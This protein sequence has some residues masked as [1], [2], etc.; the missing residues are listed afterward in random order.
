MNQSCELKIIESDQYYY[1]GNIL[2]KEQLFHIND[3]KGYTYTVVGYDDK[4]YCAEID[5]RFDR[6]VRNIYCGN[7]TS[8]DVCKKR[9][10]GLMTISCDENYLYVLAQDFPYRIR[11]SIKRGELMNSFAPF[12]ALNYEVVLTSVNVKSQSNMIAEGAK[13]CDKCCGVYA[14]ISS[15]T[16]I[17]VKNDVKITINNTNEGFFL[18]MTVKDKQY[19]H[20]RAKCVFAGRNA[21]VEDIYFDRKSITF[22]GAPIGICRYK[23]IV[24][25]VGYGKGAS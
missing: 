13:R 4:V 2:T 18:L 25:I 14:D 10:N 12:I 7:I 21:F 11:H 19:H 5:L 9:M 17:I 6:L 22:I 3:E 15:P 24:V 16:C 20:V 8:K 23:K 1:D